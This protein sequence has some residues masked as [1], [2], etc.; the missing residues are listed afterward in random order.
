MKK[1]YPVRYSETS[2]VSSD[3]ERCLWI[4][5]KKRRWTKRREKGVEGCSN[6]G[7]EFC[8]RH[9][10]A[11][12][13]V[14]NTYPHKKWQSCIPPATGMGS[15]AGKWEIPGSSSVTPAWVPEAGIPSRPSP[16]GRFAGLDVHVL[17]SGLIHSRATDEEASG[18]GSVKG[19]SQAE[20]TK[21]ETQKAYSASLGFPAY[22]HAANTIHTNL[23]RRMLRGVLSIHAL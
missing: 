13:V 18:G 21:I 4:I 5:R 2:E 15:L 12:V 19:S 1:F 8:P 9:L 22:R 23:L 16:S 14:N 20:T 3:G 11:I 6:E 17:A 10:P 7:N